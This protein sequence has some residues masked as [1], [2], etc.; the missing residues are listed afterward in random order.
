MN[1]LQYTFPA[2]ADLQEILVAL[3]GELPFDTFEEGSEFLL[4]FVPLP[5][6]VPAFSAE[7]QE[8]VEP[9]GV[10]FTVE[11]IPYQNW[12]SI[13]ESNFQ[14]ISVGNFCGVRAD[15]HEPMQGVEHEIII[16]PNTIHTNG[17]KITR[18]DA[19]MICLNM[20]VVK[21]EHMP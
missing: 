2:S 6:D 9:L 14:P 13:W 21:N 4:A 11:E 1:Y 7:V 19:I 3:L 12:N 10:E 20:N 15:F 8:I 17:P 5:A 18:S 16:N